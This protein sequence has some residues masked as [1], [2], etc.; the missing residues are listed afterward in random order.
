MSGEVNLVRMCNRCVMDTSA[1]EIRFGAEGNCSFCSGMIAQHAGPLGK[2]DVSEA[3][4][5]LVER[6]RRQGLGKKYDC[7]VGVSG[8]VDSAWALTQAVQEGL[9]PLAVHMDNGWDSE[10]AQSNIANLIAGLDVDL[11]THVIDWPE[12]RG[13]MQAFLDADVIDIELLYDNAM[14]AVNY[15]AARRFGT[16]FILSGSNSATEGMRMPTEWNWYKRD[17]ANIKSISAAHGGPFIDTFPMFST[18]EW[19]WDTYARRIRWVPFLDYTDYVKEDA[20][21]YLERN[22]GFRRYE[23][24]HGESIFTRFYQGFL[25][26]R[27]FGVDKRRLHYA[28]LVVAGQMSREEALALLELDPYSD[29]RELEDDTAYFL[30]KMRWSAA[31]LEAYLNRPPRPHTDY[32]SERWMYSTLARARN[33]VS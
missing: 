8:G 18:R 27:K 12:Y 11:Y 25:L 30:R 29:P 24:K 31:D 5:R 23:N 14:L 28:T 16:R 20:L 21:E 19:L 4:R 7:I 10:L 9:R 32:R 22:L 17:A 13:L 26:P 2:S 3:K 33:I 1:V 6:I 15:A